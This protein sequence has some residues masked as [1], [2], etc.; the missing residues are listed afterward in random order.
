MRSLF[1]VN[2]L[3]ALLDPGH[4]HHD[5][6]HAWWSGNKTDGWATC[7]LTENGFLRIVTQPRYPVRLT[8]AEA[9]GR[10]AREIQRPDHE[11]WPDTLSIADSRVFDDRR[12]LGP[13]QITD[14]YLLG[15]A[16]KHGGRLVTLD[17]A[18]PPG[19]VKGAAP[20]HLV[21]L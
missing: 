4:V 11:F 13:N 14:V 6:T 8:P 21:K 5:A 15:L 2:V 18:V 1:D 9:I 3:I 12:I 20:K 17:S 16:V 19:A 10:L 7:P